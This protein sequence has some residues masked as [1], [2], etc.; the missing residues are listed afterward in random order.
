MNCIKRTLLIRRYYCV[1]DVCHGERTEG[2]K[3]AT[4]GH[5]K[6]LRAMQTHL[7]YY[8]TEVFNSH[9][10]QVARTIWLG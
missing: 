6:R 2:S 10:K 7:H 4:E 9:E 5:N 1:C 3:R 8:W